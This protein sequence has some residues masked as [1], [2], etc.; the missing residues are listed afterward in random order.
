M[1]KYIQ[2]RV[3]EEDFKKIKKKAIDAGLSTEEFL[4]QGALEKIERM[5]TEETDRKEASRLEE[6][7]DV[8]LPNK[9]Q[10]KPQQN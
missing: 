3:G 2:A 9:T 5:D 4:K 7:F 6:I 1:I 8:T 10:P